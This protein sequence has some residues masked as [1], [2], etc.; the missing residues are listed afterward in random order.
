M[1]EDLVQETYILKPG[2]K[3]TPDTLHR[4]Q[5]DFDYS[6]TD[7]EGFTVEP[8]GLW[9]ETFIIEELFMPLDLEHLRQQIAEIVDEFVDDTAD[10]KQIAVDRILE[11]TL[12][13]KQ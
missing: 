1:S 3:F 6:V 2:I 4:D 10:I 11:V 13:R 12:G 8:S 7:V 9:F 5:N